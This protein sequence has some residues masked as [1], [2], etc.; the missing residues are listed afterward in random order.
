LIAALEARL[1]N[2]MPA[3]TS[4]RQT[5]LL[6]QGKPGG[7]KHIGSFRHVSQR[8]ADQFLRRSAPPNLE[9]SNLPEPLEPV[10]L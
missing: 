3:S 6:R 4:N 10:N 8:S 7:G 2:T 9:P 1:A 5:K